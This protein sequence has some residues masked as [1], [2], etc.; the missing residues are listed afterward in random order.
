MASVQRR[1]KA[2]RKGDPTMALG[3]SRSL[4]PE[5]DYTTANEALHRC[6]LRDKS[7]PCPLGGDSELS[8]FTSQ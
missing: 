8:L 2:A 7:D 3:D 5:D 6:A 4:M 1:G